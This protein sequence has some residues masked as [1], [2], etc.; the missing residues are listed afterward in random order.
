[1]GVPSCFAKHQFGRNNC[2]SA[3]L[4]R[5]PLTSNRAAAATIILPG[6]ID[7]TAGQGRNLEHYRHGFVVPSPEPASSSSEPSFRYHSRSIRQRCLV[8]RVA[9]SN[10]SRDCSSQ[11]AECR[12]RSWRHQRSVPC[13]RNRL[14]TLL[15]VRDPV[16]TKL[17]GRARPSLEVHPS[18]GPIGFPLPGDPVFPLTP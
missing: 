11:P 18:G 1:M 15:V 8:R 17:P 6:G 2:V 12:M 4:D 7:V 3:S 13:R 5:S 9:G 16:E 10:A 14:R